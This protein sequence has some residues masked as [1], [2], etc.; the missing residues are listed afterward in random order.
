MEILWLFNTEV[1]SLIATRGEIEAMRDIKLALCIPTYNRPEV[2]R[3][4]LEKRFFY[5]WLHGFDIYIYDSSENDYTESIVHTWIKKYE[6]LHYVKVDSKIHSNLKVYNIFKE[7]GESL[8]YDYLWVCADAISWSERVLN[9]VTKAMQR[10]YDIIIPSYRDVENIGNKEYTDENELFLDCA[11]HMT[12][13][14]ATILKVSSMLTKVNWDGLIEKY[15]VPECINHSHVAFYFEKISELENWSAIFLSFNKEDMPMSSFKKASGWKRETF[16]VWCYCW[17]TMI[18]KLPDIYKNKNE[19]IKKNG[20]NSRVLGYS[21]LKTLRKE[22]I[23]DREIYQRYKKEWGHLT[24]VPRFTIWILSW[25]PRNLLF[26]RYYYKELALKK[27]IVKFCRRY[28][29]IYIYGAGK[30]ADRYTRYLN[31]LGISF[32]AYLVSTM[33]ENDSIKENHKVIPYNDE[34]IKDEKNGILFALNEKH[35]REVIK[36]FSDK[37]NYNKIFSESKIKKYKWLIK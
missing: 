21:N 14:G 3:E 12:L 10:G 34:L 9:S 8:R 13:Y 4:F 27:K 30:K 31:E 28:D 36:D 17:P 5:Y 25:I 23:L 22:K 20:V 1:L 2:I 18:N 11:W 37:V 16:Y 15:I 29:K 6:K 35:T 19:V 26:D 24:D 7:F 33:D 32:E